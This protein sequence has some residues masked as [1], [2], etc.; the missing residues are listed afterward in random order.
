MGLETKIKFTVEKYKGINT[1]FIPDFVQWTLPANLGEK[2]VVESAGKCGRRRQDKPSSHFWSDNHVLKSVNGGPERWN[3][4]FTENQNSGFLSLR[5]TLP[6]ESFGYGFIIN[7]RIGR[8]CSGLELLTKKYSHNLKVESYFI[9][10]ECLAQEAASQELWENCSKEAGGRVR[11]YTSLQQ[12]EQA[13]RTSEIRDQVKERSILCVG[14]CK[15]LGS[16]SSFLS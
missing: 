2:V 5:P 7:N 6:P 15:P 14:W 3:K 8:P 12:G 4:S 9:W 1:S 16:L 13:V 10:W 11:L